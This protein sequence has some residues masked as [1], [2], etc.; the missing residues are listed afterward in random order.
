MLLEIFKLIATLLGGG[1]AGAALNR[2]FQNRSNKLQR[3][4]VIERVNRLASPKLQGVTLARVVTESN[5]RHLEE[6]T[7]LREYQLTLRNDAPGVHLK[8]AEIQFEFPTEDV[9]GWTTRPA[10]SK[11]ALIS[12]DCTPSDPWKK[13][14][15]GEFRIS[16]RMIPLNSRSKLS[17]L[18]RTNL[19]QLYITAIGSL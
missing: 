15:G 16:R 18:L 17:I 11:T 8:D 14:F 5:G 9:E 7:N 6:L 4:H 2:W 12:V 13:H 19:K 3:I 10:L 1:L